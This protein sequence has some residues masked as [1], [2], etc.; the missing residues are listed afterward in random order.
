MA[1]KLSL[2][3][4]AGIFVLAAFTVFITWR[5]KKLETSLTGQ[6]ETAV[7]VNKQAPTFSLPSLSGNQVSLAD[8]R[9]KKVVVSFWASWCGPCRR[10]MPMLR[11]FYEQYHQADSN[12]QFLA[13]SLDDNRTD[14]AKYAAEENLPFPVLLDLTQQVGQE[15]GA[16][17]IPTLYVINEEG[18]VVYGQVG[19]NPTIQFRLMQL[20]GIKI[21]PTTLG[22]VHVNPGD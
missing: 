11:S 5:A 9:G 13:V 8:Y 16:D 4:I 10:E 22:T 6:A 18:K 19:F 2:A 20:L 14:P 3:Q 12:F 7:M 1:R 15:Y 17:A 21:T